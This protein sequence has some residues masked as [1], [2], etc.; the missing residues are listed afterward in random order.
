MPSAWNY[1]DR[2]K[3]LAPYAAAF[4]VFMYFIP[5]VAAK[6]GTMYED[7]F[8]SVVFVTLLLTQIALH[9][10]FICEGSI[11]NPAEWRGGLACGI[12]YASLLLLLFISILWKDFGAVFGIAP[13]SAADLLYSFIVPL[14]VIIAMEMTKYFRSRSPS[15]KNDGEEKEE[16]QTGKG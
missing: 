11:L 14:A 1:T 8:S 4:A 2:V 6:A 9:A 7:S 15:G 12:Y 10:I 13:V 5:F 16:E 3:K